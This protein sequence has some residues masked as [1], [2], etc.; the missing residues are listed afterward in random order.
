MSYMYM[1]THVYMYMTLHIC[2]YLHVYT[3]IY[4]NMYI[5]M[6]CIYM[7]T[8]E[9]TCQCTWFS[10]LWMSSENISV[11]KAPT[12]PGWLTSC[13]GNKIQQ[14]SH[15]TILLPSSQ[16]NTLLLRVHIYTTTQNNYIELSLCRGFLGSILHKC[17]CGVRITSYQL[18]LLNNDF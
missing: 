1:Y 11:I 16:V 5:S 7:Y 13:C 10:F 17:S 4:P 14:L 12:F 8:H 6:Y 15:D 3:Y 9:N 18:S 2:A